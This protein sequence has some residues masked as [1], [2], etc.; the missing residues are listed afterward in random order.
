MEHQEIKCVDWSCGFYVIMHLFCIWMFHRLVM[1][2][3]RD[4]AHILIN[5]CFRPVLAGNSACPPS[6]HQRV[7]GLNTQ[8]KVVHWVHVWVNCLNL[9]IMFSKF[10]GLKYPL[11]LRDWAKIL[12]ESNPHYT[13]LTYK[14][15][16]AQ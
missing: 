15:F 11:L 2:I 4:N 12:N 6:G 1:L 3:L 14:A 8:F 10:L 5:G 13:M 16:L 7:W 9:E